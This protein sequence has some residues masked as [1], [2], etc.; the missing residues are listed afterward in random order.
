MSVWKISI[1]LNF[2][3][4]VFCFLMGSLL[5]IPIGLLPITP[6]F[7]QLPENLYGIYY[8]VTSASFCVLPL[9]SVFAVRR[10]PPLPEIGGFTFLI[11]LLCGLLFPAIA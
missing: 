10:Y 2:R 6:V 5:S 1:P 8:Y 3:T 11:F 4:G 9:W 7:W